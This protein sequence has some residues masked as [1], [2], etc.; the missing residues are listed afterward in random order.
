MALPLFFLDKYTG[1]DEER[2]RLVLAA[3]TAL[4]EAR[5]ADWRQCS[6]CGIKL[7]NMKKMLPLQEN[8]LLQ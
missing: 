6:N 4:L 7:E 3:Q 5:M 2:T 1:T 8:T